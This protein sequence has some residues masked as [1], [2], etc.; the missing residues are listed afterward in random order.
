MH[1][2]A[3]L[4][5]LIGFPSAAHAY[6]D[7]IP[8]DH[9]P[10]IPRTDRDVVYGM[11]DESRWAC[12]RP[13]EAAGFPLLSNLKITPTKLPDGVE[14]F[15]LIVS[16][17]DSNHDCHPTDSIS[18]QPRHLNVLI[19]KNWIINYGCDLNHRDQI[20]GFRLKLLAVRPI[21]LP[22]QIIDSGEVLGQNLN[23]GGPQ[24]VI[25]RRG[26]AEFKIELEAN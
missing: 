4:L 20:Y 23:D 16:V 19:S 14:N 5:L 17:C 8:A 6:F 11:L 9:L 15:Q 3:L 26:K 7:F 13:V 22:N 24:T 10:P 12:V 2:F 25:T 1:R 21:Y 18:F